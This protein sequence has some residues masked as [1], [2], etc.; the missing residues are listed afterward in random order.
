MWTTADGYTLRV[1]DT[2]LR[3]LTPRFEGPGLRKLVGDTY[4]PDPLRAVHGALGRLARN[5]FRSAGLRQRRT[6]RLYWLFTT[7]AGGR[8]YRL[9]ARPD[10]PGR[11]SVVSVRPSLSEGEYSDG[12]GHQV[13]QTA[14]VNEL[15]ARG[16]HLQQGNGVN[17][18]PR[19]IRVNRQQISSRTGKAK[20]NQV[21][22]VSY[23]AANGMRV[24][25]EFDTKPENSRDHLRRQALNDPDAYIIGVVIDENTGRVISRRVYDPTNMRDRSNRFR[26]RLDKNFTPGHADT[27]NTDLLG[28]PMPGTFTTQTPPPPPPVDFGPVPRLPTSRPAPAGQSR[29]TR[30]LISR[31][32]RAQ[33]QPRQQRPQ[34]QPGQRRQQ[35]PA[36]PAVRPTPPR[37][38]GG[39]TSRPR[40]PAGGG[41]PSTPPPRRTP[42]RQRESEAWFEFENI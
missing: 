37:P 10:G 39:G 20:D 14:L 1:S 30:R 25:V 6:G 40:G 22:D 41:R 27:V 11:A 36:P 13:A 15:I 12:H 34:G 35:R 29:R 3:R 9:L 7:H 33:A 16:L 23:V 26:I 42:R 24:N 4:A 19:V 21:P 5:A 8:A 17:L 31:H 32:T 38:S 28:L 2:R 18:D